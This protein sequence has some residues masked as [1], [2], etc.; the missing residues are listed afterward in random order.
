MRSSS[1]FYSKL[2]DLLG[3]LL[4]TAFFEGPFGLGLRRP[5]FEVHENNRGRDSVLARLRQALCARGLDLKN[6]LEGLIDQIDSFVPALFIDDSRSPAHVDILA[7][8]EGPGIDGSYDVVDDHFEA[9]GAHPGLDRV[10]QALPV[11]IG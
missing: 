11:A 9:R 8:V 7:C 3:C 10:G 1:R 2:L 6:L 4:P 5:A